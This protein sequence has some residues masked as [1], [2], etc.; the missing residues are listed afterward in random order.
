MHDLSKLRK[1]PD[2]TRAEF[3]A[4]NVTFDLDDLL[5]RDEIRRTLIQQVDTLKARRNEAGKKIGEM[6]KSGE[7]ANDIID[8]MGKLG[9]EIEGIDAELKGLHTGIQADL[10][11]LPNLPH[12]S[13]PVGRDETENIVERT[14][15]EPRDFDFKVLDHVDLGETLRIIDP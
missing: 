8:D 12:K 2:R 10:L 13:V 7:D 14:W 4:R 15:G 6:K 9:L 5:G 3:S 1:D 11:G